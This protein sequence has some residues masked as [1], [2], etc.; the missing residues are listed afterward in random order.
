MI[1]ACASNVDVGLVINMLTT[2]GALGRKWSTIIC[3]PGML[4][5]TSGMKLQA[6]N[7]SAAMYRFD[8]FQLTHLSEKQKG[9]VRDVIKALQSVP[10]AVKILK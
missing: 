9:I 8:G 6:K 10:N 3:S 4:L 1:S 2:A 7:L 5:S